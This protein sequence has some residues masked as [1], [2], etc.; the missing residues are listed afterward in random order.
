MNM[1][2]QRLPYLLNRYLNKSC[3][4]N[5]LA[6]FYA[7]VND[8][9]NEME[10]DDLLSDAIY[11]T[12]GGYHLNPDRKPAVLQHIFNSGEQEV[13]VAKPLL[14]RRGWNWRRLSTIAALLLLISTV[15]L[16]FFGVP[17]PFDKGD[18]QITANH[19]TQILPG[20]NNAILTLSNGIVI[21]LQQAENGKLADEGNVSVTK[22][23]NGQLIYNINNTSDKR[24]INSLSINTLT[25]PRGG[26][27]QLNL[28]DGSKVWLNAA[29]SLKFPSTFTGLNQRKVELSGEAYFE[30]AKVTVKDKS[31]RNKEVRLPFIVV[32][33]RQKV[34]VLGT[35]FNVNAYTDELNTKTTLLE[36]SVKVTDADERHTVT[37]KP[38]QQSVL[39][40]DALVIERADVEKGIDWKSGKFIF[41][42]ESLESI[43]R[44]VARWYDVE[45][46]YAGN[47]PKQ[48]TFSGTVSRFDDVE[49]V[50]RR[51]ELTGEVRFKINGRQITV[52]K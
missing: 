5:E 47:V 1:M 8:P 44:K 36:G 25:T 42:N 49:K 32:T 27:Y 29:S 17:R 28:P 24:S 46:I 2:N 51:L 50:L 15:G 43:M 12:D 16:Y 18:K 19:K 6:E 45:V 13:P 34:E 3:S 30:I 14:V 37:L 40:A 48:E 10:F 52:L 31:A 7:L 23:K 39:N 9:A 26:Q 38:G 22:N 20:G 11:N 4:G 41:K 35:H 21:N 33:G